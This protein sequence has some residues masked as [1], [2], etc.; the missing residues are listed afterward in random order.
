MPSEAT[1]GHREPSI[2]IRRRNRLKPTS[3][4]VITSAPEDKKQNNDD[5]KRL[6]IHDLQSFL[7]LG[8]VCG[9]FKETYSVLPGPD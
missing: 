9:F 4:T 3:P 2:Y 5:E 7:R 8:I 6:G 1:P